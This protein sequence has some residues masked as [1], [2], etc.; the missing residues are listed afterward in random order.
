MG[1]DDNWDLPLTQATSGF[2]INDPNWLSI[3]GWGPITKSGFEENKALAKSTSLDQLN[4][5]KN[6]LGSY[7][8]PTQLGWDDTAAQRMTAAGI[9]TLPS[10]FNREAVYSDAFHLGQGTDPVQT[11]IDLYTMPYQDAISKW[12]GAKESYNTLAGIDVS[13]EYQ[14]LSNLEDSQFRDAYIKDAMARM[15]N[16]KDSWWDRN[17][18]WVI[19]AG[20]VASVAAG[21]LLS[22]F[23]S[24]TGALAS[25]AST[26][27][28][29]SSEATM[30]ISDM[31]AANAAGSGSLAGMG[32]AELGL[33]N[34]TPLAG[35]GAETAGDWAT[36]VGQMAD[37]GMGSGTNWMTQ[38][39]LPASY[40]AADLIGTELGPAILNGSLG[41]SAG[42][43]G[44]GL[45]DTLYNYGSKLFGGGGSGGTTGNTGDWSGILK[46]LL[47]I[48]GAVGGGIMSNN[49]MQDSIDKAQKYYKPYYDLGVSNIPALNAADPT[50]GA[51]QFMDQLKSYG[52]NFKFD[53]T[54]P[55]Y[56]QKLKLAQ[57]ANDKALAARGMFNSR[58]GLNLQDETA[59]NVQAQEYEAQY[60]R[61][62]QNLMDLFKMSSALGGTN[63]GKL[64][65]M[66]KIG[67]GASSSA[68]AASVAGGQSEANLWSG[69]GA[70]PMNYQILMNLLNKGTK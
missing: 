9:T 70:M 22:E 1:Y 7:Y 4:Y 63:Y 48:G 62:Y 52:T 14:G 21:G 34:T 45:L 5:I 27:P 68:G 67:S 35:T 36:A 12:S 20:S 60:N 24:P 61:G 25:G 28:S 18:D 13:G 64:L 44:V 30:S 3:A 23:L 47:T 16:A 33:S 59:R 40:S 56:T 8:S 53:T 11:Y 17:Q 41:L 31:M 38:L 29:L 58:A 54:N 26:A 51:G 55:A 69:L 42:G 6:R 66:V 39:G 15:F 19:G 10:W 43:G 46:S 50:G 37:V 65:D 32:G 49:A 2:D 57:E